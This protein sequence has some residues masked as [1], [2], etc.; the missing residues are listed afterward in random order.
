MKPGE[1]WIVDLGLAAKV[2]PCLL[3]TDYPQESERMLVTIVPHTTSVRGTP[4]EIP[5]NKGFLKRGA[6]DT[7]Q[8]QSIDPTKLV[9]RIGALTEGELRAIRRPQSGTK[10]HANFQIRRR[11]A[12][13]YPTVWLTPCSRSSE[14]NAALSPLPTNLKRQTNYYRPIS[15]LLR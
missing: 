9:R 2:R 1:V 10:V 8:I 6:F 13:H 7:Q 5:I 12:A 14:K 3:L 11:S 15:R 4:W